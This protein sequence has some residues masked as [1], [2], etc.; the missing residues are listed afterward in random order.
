MAVVPADMGN[1]SPAPCMVVG[2]LMGSL[3]AISIFIN[4]KIGR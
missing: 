4:E 3:S 1:T 2:V